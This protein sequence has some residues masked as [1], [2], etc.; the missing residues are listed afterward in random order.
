METQTG[1]N[2]WVTNYHHNT[3]DSVSEKEEEKTMDRP[4]GCSSVLCRFKFQI[5]RHI[6]ILLRSRE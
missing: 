4:T 6:N 2:S 1:G 5:E 3:L